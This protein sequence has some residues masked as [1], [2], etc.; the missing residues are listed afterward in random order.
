MSL[1]ARLT[2]GLIVV[3]AIGLLVVGAVVYAEQRSFLLKRVD[4]QVRSAP[5]AL[6]HQLAEQ[7]V[8]PFGA[9]RFPPRGPFG[10]EGRPGGPAPANLPP[11]TYG[12]LRGPSGSS[13]GSVMR[14]IKPAGAN[15]AA[16]RS[17][18]R[19]R[20]AVHSSRCG[21]FTRSTAA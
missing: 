11:G 16:Y 17:A 6:G 15:N 18:L 12:E 8:L 9:R 7:G 10:G 2:A 1:R 13:I 14:S 3:A 4:E 5:P 20:I 19:C 21:S